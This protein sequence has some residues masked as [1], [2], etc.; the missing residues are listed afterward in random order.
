MGNIT[1]ITSRTFAGLDCVEF[2]SIYFS[3]GIEL[4]IEYGAF[5]S[6]KKLKMLDLN[7][8]SKSALPE[9][10]QDGHIQVKVE[11]VLIRRATSEDDV[12]TAE[13]TSVSDYAKHGCATSENCLSTV[14]E[15]H[16]ILT[17]PNSYTRQAVW[18]GYAALFPYL[19]KNYWV[20]EHPP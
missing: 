8:I 11:G 16:A 14:Y 13:G 2:L 7:G 12:T 1:N 18:L 3:N 10:L 9:D 20:A 5:D 4:I 6:L 17:D 15:K 19:C